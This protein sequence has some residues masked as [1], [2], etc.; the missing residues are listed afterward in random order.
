MGLCSL[1]CERSCPP[2]SQFDICPVC[3]SGIARWLD[4]ARNERLAY[5]AKLKVRTLRMEEITGAS[6]E[7]YAGQL[8]AKRR[9]HV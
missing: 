1:G 8:R 3:R 5:E 6:K 7:S 2:N 4:R 9:A